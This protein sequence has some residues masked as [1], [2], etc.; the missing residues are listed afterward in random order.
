LDSGGYGQLYVDGKLIKAHRLA[1]QLENG[2]IPEGLCVLHHCDNRA[3]CNPAH[4]FLGT[5][6]DNA[7][8]MM[9][10]GRGGR[11][12]QNGNAK[13]TREQVRQIRKL[14]ATGKYPQKEL[15][16]QFEISPCHISYIVT[17]KRWAWLD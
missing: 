14:Y 1:W 12:A 3:C 6:S 7:C 13:L 10:K 5:Y 11:G 2:S 16:E 17:R 15:V 8:D 4:L 9:N